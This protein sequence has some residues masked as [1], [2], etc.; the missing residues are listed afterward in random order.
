MKIMSNLLQLYWNDRSKIIIIMSYESNLKYN[1]TYY[2]YKLYLNFILITI[3]KIY[4]H[5]PVKLMHCNWNRKFCI[6]HIW[7]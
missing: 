3:L 5:K 7:N 4:E 2:I 6:N 1:I